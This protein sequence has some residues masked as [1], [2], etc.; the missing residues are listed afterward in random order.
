MIQKLR[1][2]ITSITKQ[3][4]KNK[5]IQSNVTMIS[6][7]TTKS[8]ISPIVL[9]IIIIILFKQIIK[10]K[11]KIMIINNYSL[12]N[13]AKKD[14]KNIMM[15]EVEHWGKSSIRMNMKSTNAN[16]RARLISQKFLKINLIYQTTLI[17]RRDLF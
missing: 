4:K 9:I 17:L 1:A 7:K 11:G 2:I 15:E 12:S 8:L 13:L 16:L 5:R 10:K 6:Q 14:N 3:M